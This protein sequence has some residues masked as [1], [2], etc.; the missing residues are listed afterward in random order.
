MTWDPNN[1]LATDKIRA[2]PNAVTTKNWPQLETMI[3]ADHQFNNTPAPNDNSGYHKVVRYV[4]QAGAIGD[5]TPAAAPVADTAELYTKSLVYRKEGGTGGTRQVLMQ[6]PGNRA[7]AAEE[8]AI[9]AAPIRAAAIIQGGGTIQGGAFNITSVAYTGVGNIYLITMTTAMPSTDY[10]V[11][12]TL[13]GGNQYFFTVTVV[14]TTQ[15][16][17]ALYNNAGANNL[18]TDFNVIVLGGWPTS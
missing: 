18:Q 12:A 5:D 2:W 15:F 10:L 13:K 17:I 7:A 4:N 9:G 3:E 8:S 1:P 11:I 14:S 16:R 6:Q